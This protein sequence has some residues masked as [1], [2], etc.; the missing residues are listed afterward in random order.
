MAVSLVPFQ[1]KEVVVVP[2]ILANTKVHIG[3]HRVLINN[4]NSGK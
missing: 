1:G 3:N 4:F 2:Y